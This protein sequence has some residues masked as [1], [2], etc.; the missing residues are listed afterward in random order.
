[1]N[2]EVIRE[3]T[4]QSYD[5]VYSP[6]LGGCD[7]L[8]FTIPKQYDGQLVKNYDDVRGRNLIKMIQGETEVGYFEI[9]NP[10][11]QNNGLKE[12]KNVKALSSEIKLIGKKIYLTD[13]VFKFYDDFNI[14]NGIL[15]FVVSKIK[16]WTI[17]YVD[18]VLINK[19]RYFD[20]ADTNVYEFLM[21]TVQETFECAFIFDTINKRINAYSLENFGESSPI[22]VSLNNIIKDADVEELSD[23]IVTKLHL[24][25]ENGV[26][27]RDI[28]FGQDF[29]VNYDYFK[30]TEFMSQELIDALDDY[31]S[32][33]SS[34]STT[35]SGYLTSLNSLYSQLVTAQSDLAILEDEL[36]SLI[37]QKSYLQSIGQSTSSIQTQINNKQSQINTRENQIT[38][39]EANINSI[40]GNIDSIIN[41]ISMENNFTEAQLIELEEFIIEDTYQDPSFLV[42]DLAT[43]AE[44]VEVQRD[45]LETGQSILARVSYPRYRIKIDVVDFLKNKEFANWWDK[46]H[47]GDIIRVN[48]DDSFV[49][50]VRVTSYTHSWDD[51]KLTINLGDKYKFDDGVIELI[52]LLKS[53]ISTSTNVNYER[54]KYKDYTSNNKNEILEFINSSIDLNKNAVVGGTNQEMLFD[55]SGLLMRR[56]EPSANDYS[57]KQLKVTNNAIVLTDDA[58]NTAKTAIGQLSNGLYGIA[59]EVIAGKMILGNNMIIE[60]GNGDFRVDGSGVNITKLSINMTSSDNL[61]NILI[62]PNV[63]F[64]MRTRTSTSQA[65]QDSLYVDPTSKKLK[66]NGDLEAVGGTFSGNLSAAG[67]TFTG[68]LSG[69]NGT[70]SGSLQAA[71]GT[72]TGTVQAGGVIGSSIVGGSA[73]FGN[74]A[75]VFLGDFSGEGS[76][77]FRDS[78]GTNVFLASYRIISDEVQMRT[79]NSKA[80]SISSG[81]GELNLSGIPVNITSNGSISLSSFSGKILFN[82]RPMVSSQYVA[83]ISD[84]PSTSS[85]VT[86]PALYSE[87]SSYATRSYAVQDRSTQNIALQ[88]ISANNSLEVWVNGEYKGA[89]LLI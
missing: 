86:Y 84:I 87:L 27:V 75:K 46:L 57:P 40:E 13:G 66:F 62:D 11:T 21:N 76:L 24:Y 33:I 41:I 67:G 16:G 85:F 58:F 48:V 6:Q 10:Q 77:A 61:K 18:P 74:N 29:I 56:W 8:S 35:Y 53:S 25:G 44:S 12:V 83:L 23:E 69:V 64:K 38:S 82:T 19:E 60:T 71:S 52:D 78:S 73:T 55:Q 26:T 2:G 80:L 1:M 17:G 36:L 22:I 63:G 72:F 3:I 4:N 39:I 7:A 30:T 51:N 43:Y 50:D 68:T 79:L 5:K 81:F 89:T 65:F 34:Y 14:N 42:S 54:Y 88:W 15:N 49:V 32:L 28:N 70:F 31:D 37:E 9:Q 47:I 59:A 20:I 45:L